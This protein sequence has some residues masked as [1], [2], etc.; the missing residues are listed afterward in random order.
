M[1]GHNQRTYMRLGNSP[2]QTE[3]DKCVTNAF[4]WDVC[5][6]SL[7]NYVIFRILIK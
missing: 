1:G 4:F 5:S 2:G 7:S 3:D 6:K